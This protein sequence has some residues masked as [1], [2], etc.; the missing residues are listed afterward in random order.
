MKKSQ[1]TNIISLKHKQ[2]AMEKEKWEAHKKKA[3]ERFETNFQELKHYIIKLKR[4]PTADDD[5]IL[6]RWMHQQMVKHRYGML[7]DAHEAKFKEINFLW[8]T[9][10]QVWYTKAELMKNF[11]KTQ[12]K[13]PNG[14]GNKTLRNWFNK[15]MDAILSDRAMLEVE[16]KVIGEVFDLIAS[17]DINLTEYPS[18]LQVRNKIIAVQNKLVSLRNSPN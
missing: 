3:L 13:L 17:L 16:I 9:P 14:K 4:Y 15:T 12:G 11:F 18:Q 10:Q 6:H 5:E 1:Q 2:P 7:L 8:Q